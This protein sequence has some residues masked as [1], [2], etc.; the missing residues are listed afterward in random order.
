MKNEQRIARRLLGAALCSMLLMS[1]GRA[2]VVLDHDEGVRVSRAHVEQPHVEQPHVEQPHVEQPHVDDSAPAQ[3]MPEQKP[4]VNDKV[5]A[6]HRKTLLGPKPAAIGSPERDTAM[7]ALVRMAEPAHRVLR[8]MLDAF[9]DPEIAT[10]DTVARFLTIL[11]AELSVDL[12]SGAAARGGE[13][14]NAKFAQRIEIYQRYVPKLLALDLRLDGVARR[15]GKSPGSASGGKGGDGTAGAK[16][17]AAQDSGTKATTNRDGGTRTGGAQ[18]TGQDATGKAA[19]ATTSQQQPASAGGD[20]PQDPRSAVVRQRIQAFIRRVPADARREALKKAISEASRV[21]LR[22]AAV[23]YAG[24]TQDPKIAPAIAG[25]LSVPDLQAPA[26]EALRLL[27]W[28]AKPFADAKDFETW[29]AEHGDR[30]YEELTLR[31][32]QRAQEAIRELE[33]AQAK[34]RARLQALLAER[35]VLVVELAVAQAEPR[36]GLVLA[37]LERHEAGGGADAVLAR[38]A[39]TLAQREVSDKASKSVD[40]VKLHD[41]LRGRAQ[42]STS[43]NKAAGIGLLRAWIECAR[44]LRG[45]ANNNAETFLLGQ[46]GD[47]TAQPELFA[48]LARFATSQRVKLAVVKVAESLQDNVALG[49]ALD[50]IASL[51]FDASND[52]EKALRERVSKLLVGKVLDAKRPHAIREQALRG[53]GELGPVALPRLRALVVSAEQGLRKDLMLRLTAFQWSVL[54]AAPSWQGLTGDQLRDAAAEHLGFLES[55]LADAEARVRL[56]AA[57]A[58]GRF[59]PSNVN[60]DPDQLRLLV[61]KLIASVGARLADEEDLGTIKALRETLVAQAE[62]VDEHGFALQHIV[63]ALLRWHG[64]AAKRKNL[65]SA[66]T[67]LTQDEQRL[68]QGPIDT[69]AGIVVAKRFV[70]AGLADHAMYWLVAPSL[71]KLDRDADKGNGDPDVAKE[72]RKRAGERTALV[73]R[74]LQGLDTDFAKLEGSRR[75]QVGAML[76]T[77]DSGLRKVVTEHPA[78][79]FALGLAHADKKAHGDAR[80]AFQLLITSKAAGISDALRTT[81]RLALAREAIADGKP[82]KAVEALA[83]RSD[84]ASLELIGRAQLNAGKNA[85]AATAFRQVLGKKDGSLS[86]QLEAQCRLGLIDALL[87]QQKLEGVAKLLATPVPADPKLRDRHSLLKAEFEK[88]QKAKKGGGKTAGPSKDS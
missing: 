60:F 78:A 54:H 17:G 72:I 20:A 56:S 39:D 51:V 19:K 33:A 86:P 55:C 76:R 50:C 30:A 67:A 15:N 70:D 49:A 63:A 21:D 8:E 53:L 79:V 1:L 44:L 10:H 28:R 85:E 26:R 13:E 47:G 69:E 25:L 42:A 37:E 14:A 5:I 52:E 77:C 35:S 83:G 3:P 38:F 11:S 18:G 2:H 9:P 57:Q 16:S 59:P 27:T 58:F 46:L 32:A 87:K 43:A 61:R 65:A 23:R 80:R 22:A 64:D 66:I 73:L 6:R 81:A 29:W 34:E 68:L 75:E 88:Q 7:R 71:V 31:A 41:F 24:K 74:V 48:L 12:E 62:R 84:V 4:G 82:N 36:W 45:E 40:L